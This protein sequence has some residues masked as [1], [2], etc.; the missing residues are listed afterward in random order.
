VISDLNVYQYSTKLS[1][2]RSSQ[3]LRSLPL[4]PILISKQQ[5]LFPPQAKELYTEKPTPATSGGE[6]F[7]RRCRIR[8]YFS[9]SN[10]TLNHCLGGRTDNGCGERVGLSWGSNPGTAPPVIRD[11]LTRPPEH[12]DGDC[13]LS[14]RGLGCIY[15]VMLT[16]RGVVAHYFPQ[17]WIQSSDIVHSHT[18]FL[19]RL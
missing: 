5:K 1:N 2:N 9:S 12:T 6:E 4:S 16:L 15:R 18:A 17:L 19:S 7:T 10:G 3:P 13:C 11:L 8:V 14:G